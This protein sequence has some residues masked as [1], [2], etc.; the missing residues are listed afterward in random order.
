MDSK[1]YYIYHIPGVKIGCTDNIKHRMYSYPKNTEYEILESHD[2]IYVASDREI[3]LQRRYGYPVDKTPYWQ[4][5]KIHTHESR[6][7]GGKVIG[8]KNVESGH[9]AKCR[10]LSKKVRCLVIL[11]YD[12]NGNIIKEW[13][14][15]AQ[16]SMVLKLDATN[17]TK[18]LKGKHKTCGGYT[19][20]YKLD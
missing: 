12:L 15:G 6:S 7:K 11:Q 20:K 19:F 2:D 13:E 8:K 4:T 18:V 10:E 5:L 1:T 9:L 3:L 14:S 16:A 17:I